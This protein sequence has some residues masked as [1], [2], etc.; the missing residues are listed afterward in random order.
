M[1]AVIHELWM[2]NDASAMIMPGSIPLNVPSVR[3]ELVRHLPD[4]WNSIIDREVDGK[5]SIPYQKDRAT[6]RYGQKLAA[7]RV[8]RTIMLGSAPSTS[9]LRDQSIRGLETS[10]IRLGVVQP[11]ESIADFNDALNTLHGSLSYLYNNQNGTRFWYD[12]K[13]TLR[14][15]SEDRASQVSDADVTME[16]ER[17]LKKLRGESPFSGLHSCPASSN[18][19]PDEQSARLVILRPEDNFRRVNGKDSGKALTTVAEYLNMRGTSPVFIEICW[20]LLLPTRTS[21]GIFRPN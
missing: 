7:R 17:R 13:P 21:F 18:D 2:A 14:K 1:A 16:L 19:V 4:T 15:T 3:D 12:T 6:H 20:H 8:A 11:G 9:A 5:D 10:R